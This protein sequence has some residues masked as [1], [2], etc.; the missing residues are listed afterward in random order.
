M[1]RVVLKPAFFAR[2]IKEL[3]INDRKIEIIEVV[4]SFTGAEVFVN[5]KRFSKEWCRV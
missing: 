1:D 3:S 2:T 4:R 5:L